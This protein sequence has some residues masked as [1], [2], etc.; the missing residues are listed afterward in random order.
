MPC[1]APVRPG[2]CL[3][4]RSG[5][6]ASRTHEGAHSCRTSAMESNSACRERPISRPYPSRPSHV[7][8]SARRGGR[9]RVSPPA[10][11]KVRLRPVAPMKKKFAIAR[12]ATSS[13]STPTTHRV[14]PS[15]EGQPGH[16]LCK[17]GSP[18][19][20]LLSE[21]RRDAEKSPSST[22]DAHAQRTNT[23]F[24]RALGEIGT[25]RDLPLSCRPEL[26]PT[27]AAKKRAARTA[28]FPGRCHF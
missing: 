9:G 5:R 28:A 26:R 17:G 1:N 20:I 15:P 13:G 21:R 8:L 24:C 11:G 6:R 27:A 3:S 12:C 25:R 16:S 7:V 22:Q 2:G 14:G 23:A 10:G 4:A 18:G 19:F